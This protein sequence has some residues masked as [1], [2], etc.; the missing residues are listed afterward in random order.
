MVSE[1]NI[2][3]SQFHDV[4]FEECSE[5]MEIMESG[6]LNL[7]SESDSEV[8][9][10]IFRAAH[11][12]KGGG[13]TFGFSEI[14]NF[15]HG[16][17]TILDEMRNGKLAVTPEAVELLL[18]ALDCLRDMVQSSKDKTPIN[19]ELVSEIH[20]KLENFT[21]EAVA[22]V[23]ENIPEDEPL[24]VSDEQDSV[25][26]WNISFYPH[27]NMF[28]T[29]NDP[30]RL[31]RELQC[32]GDLKTKVNY[33]RLPEF[34]KMDVQNCYLGWDLELKGDVSLDQ[35]TE[36]FEWVEDDCSLEVNLKNKVTETES[37]SENEE[38]KEVVEEV[39][40]RVKDGEKTGRRRVEKSGFSN[41]ETSSIRVGINK[42]DGLVNLVGELVITQS[43]LSRVCND[44][45]I[46]RNEKLNECLD[47]LERN[48]R[49][50]QEQTMGIRMLPIDFAFQRLPRIVHD[51]SNSLGKKVDLKFSGETTE[52][53]KTVL[54]KIGD[55]L[56]HLVRNALDHGIESSD[57][58]VAAGKSEKG[59]I[60]IN[61]YHQ[62]GNII[63][64]IHDDGAGLDPEKILNKAR[65]KGL[66]DNDEV[67]N[68]LQIQNLIFA[69]G[70]S[71][72]AVVSDVSGRGV[73]MDVVRRNMTDLGGT[74]EVASVLGKGSTFT[75][76]LPLTVAI[77][78]GQMVSIGDQVFIVPLLS[79]I[80]SIQVSEKD[81]NAI[82]NA[83]ELY[84]YR[85]EYI[86]VIRLREV[87]N[88]HIDEDD[89]ENRRGLLVVIDI[90]GRRVGLYVDDVVG[91]QQVVI[92]SLE[93]NYQQVPGI[94]G[95]TVLGDGGVALIIDVLGLVQTSNH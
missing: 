54:E 35:I 14:S 20:E 84:P 9:N 45:G 32:L 60:S 5:G 86:S 26:T 92:K 88:V 29:G 6:L 21:G 55:P 52:L 22:P 58:R 30:F 34:S 74:V 61:A 76:R 83:A 67:L 63:I 8:I 51:L 71:T 49:D 40:A 23:A 80:E 57:V 11:S 43:I 38:E 59:L 15:T 62:G 12:I 72:A 46:E 94:A 2:D 82:A 7:T 3:L 90:G 16:M 44:L 95:A 68:E 91:Q 89:D 42:V 66:V 65:E 13:G 25:S 47:Q 41:Q 53:D 70:F 36:I 39:R 4:F 19:K 37:E 28:Y 75:I 64:E 33:D 24:N 1:V 77:L 48:T 31:I 93:Q 78:E 73:G 27:E 81:I 87:F 17:E 79:I 18:E 69:P 85:D 10:T 56:M 50:L